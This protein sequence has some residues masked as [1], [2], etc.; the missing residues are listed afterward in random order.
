MARPRDTG[1]VVPGS[2]GVTPGSPPAGDPTFNPHVGPVPAGGAY[3]RKS[4]SYDQ[5]YPIVYG[6]ASVK[7]LPLVAGFDPANHDVALDGGATVPMRAAYVAYAL[8]VGPIAAVDSIIYEKRRYAAATGGGALE[9]K[10]MSR[11]VS[12]S[13]LTPP[14]I[15][16]GD[17]T[18]TAWSGFPDPTQWKSQALFRCRFLG[19]PGGAGQVPELRAVVR[20]LKATTANAKRN[21]DGLFTRYDAPPGDV[22]RDLLENAVYG[23]GLPAGTV[24]TATGAD[25]TAASSF[26]RYC[27]QNGWLIAL[28]I[29]ASISV[30]E[31]VQQILVATNSVGFWSGANFKIIPLGDS[32]VGTYSPV[33][34]AV[35]LTED[36]FV[37]ADGQDAI[38]VTRRSWADTYNVIPVEYSQDT[39]SRDTQFAQVEHM[40]AASVATYGVRRSPNTVSLPCVRSKAHAVEISGI[41]ARRSC[42]NRS[43]FEFTVSARQGAALEPGDLVGLTHSAMGLTSRLARV[44]RVE[45]APDQGTYRVEAR[46]WITGAAVTVVF[47]PPG[48]DG[49][50]AALTPPGDA[51][52]GA[53]AALAQLANI[54]SDGVLSA[55]G[56]KRSLLTELQSLASYRIYLM[57]QFLQ[58][59]PA[60]WHTGYVS[61]SEGLY[62]AYSAHEYVALQPAV[63]S[64]SRVPSSNPSYWKDM[65]AGLEVTGSPYD[66][67]NTAWAALQTYFHTTLGLTLSVYELQWNESTLNWIR[68]WVP[69]NEDAW[70]AS[71]TAI[72]PTTFLQKFS[73]YF[74]RLNGAW[75]AINA[76]IT[77]RAQAHGD[78]AIRVAT[79]TVPGQVRAGT[80]LTVASDGA[81]SVTG[82]NADTLDGYHRASGSTGPTWGSIP[83]INTDGVMEV[84]KY[85]DFHEA[86]TEA[87]D[88]S[89]RMSSAPG[90]VSFTAASGNM[91]VG[92]GSLSGAY[93][94]SLTLFSGG[95]G[96]SIINAGAGASGL[97]FQN[98][99]TQTAQLDPSGNFTA[100][101]NVTAYSD[102]RIKKKV[103]RIRGA[104][105]T[106]RA[107]RGVTFERKDSGAAGVGLIAQEVREVL[108][109]V[110]HEG[111]DGK[112]SIAYGN[113]VGVLVEAVKELSDE[114]QR[115]SKPKRKKGGRR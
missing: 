60:D 80:G 104:T 10:H 54:A 42:Y 59:R 99:G 62:V 27:D 67:W 22:I 50:G 74:D 63:A 58:M 76:R 92:L 112:L 75:L 41:L 8:G 97:L 35:G 103:R 61:A 113:L 65:G 4:P 23:L 52:G 17:G 26:D 77:A 14:E 32:A 45:S 93:T 82:G 7:A 110:V 48:A 44:E 102:R 114:V 51:Y 13:W 100:V 101:G 109:E 72:D 24:V 28:A 53:Q 56:E 31:V 88:F 46:E 106:V 33:L 43:L 39:A 29:D 107:L 95:G 68:V 12:G 91:A 89:V 38:R 85:I 84:G 11:V 57:S 66:L 78:A 105:A 36:D 73:D 90:N 96:A 115:L 34:T 1:G 3:V 94:T 20:G 70:L 5:P 83:S 71:N 55:G 37:A 47:T 98:Q 69:G 49:L 16:L 81:L 2:P 15:F 25:G 6:T 79:D 111:P 64:D 87:A 21:A 18:T 108:P 30:A 86:S 40:D 19:V 9:Y